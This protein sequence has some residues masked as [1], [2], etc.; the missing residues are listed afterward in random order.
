MWKLTVFKNCDI[1]FFDTT[2]Q[3]GDIMPEAKV[4]PDELQLFEAVK[5]LYRTTKT[6]TGLNRSLRMLIGIYNRGE[7]KIIEKILK[8]HFDGIIEFNEIVEN[9][10]PTTSV[11]QIDEPYDSVPLLLNEAP[12][13]GQ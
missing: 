4:E 3:K 10:I 13:R 11:P 6:N 2:L 8:E 7:G 9:Y 12:R 1:I 5:K